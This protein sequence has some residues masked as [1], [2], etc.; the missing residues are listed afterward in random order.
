[1]LFAVSVNAVSPW[2]I[3]PFALLLLMIA[4]MPFIHKHW[5]EHN[6][7]FVSLLLGT[8]S[9]SYYFFVLKN[10]ETILHTAHPC[11]AA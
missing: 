8:I 1:M 5:W 11:S 9:I 4:V 7:P 6:Y 2:A 10:H 3:I